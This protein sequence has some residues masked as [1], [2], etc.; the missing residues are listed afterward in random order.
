MARS[1]GEAGLCPSFCQAFLE[2]ADGF[3]AGSRSQGSQRHQADVLADEAHGAVDQQE[4]RTADVIAGE[5][6][7]V[8]VITGAVR[9]VDAVNRRSHRPVAGHARILVAGAV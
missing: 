6:M 9:T 2:F 4:L 8:A 1:P 7:A 5:R 3:S